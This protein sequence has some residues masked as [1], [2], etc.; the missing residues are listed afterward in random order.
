[1]LDELFSKYAPIIGAYLNSDGDDLCKPWL[2]VV[3]VIFE[4]NVDRELKLMSELAAAFNNASR[5]NY[6]RIAASSLDFHFI[7][8]EMTEEALI[9]AGFKKGVGYLLDEEGLRVSFNTA[10]RLVLSKGKPEVIESF[11]FIESVHQMFCRY[12]LA[13]MGRGRYKTHWT[14][15][16]R[17]DKFSK[18]MRPHETGISQTPG[19][20]GTGPTMNAQPMVFRIITGTR[21]SVV[22]LLQRV[23]KDTFSTERLVP[24]FESTIHSLDDEIDAV[25][26][27][28]TQTYA[29]PYREGQLNKPDGDGNEVTKLSKTKHS[30]KFLKNVILIDPSQDAYTREMLVQNIND[31]R[32]KLK[33]GQTTHTSDRLDSDNTTSIERFISSKGKFFDDRCLFKLSPRRDDVSV[34]EVNESMTFES[35]DSFGLN[36]RASIDSFSGSSRST[37]RESD[38]SIGTSSGGTGRRLRSVTCDSTLSSFSAVADDCADDN[39]SNEDNHV[40]DDIDEDVDEEADTPPAAPTKSTRVRTGSINLTNRAVRR[41]R[42]VS[43]NRPMAKGGQLDAIQAGD[44][45]VSEDS[46]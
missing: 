23:D 4:M 14:L 34:I 33:L 45:E 30:I 6:F 17:I 42:S 3:N 7:D 16:E 37:F 44:S 10:R 8:F 35:Y 13:M 26:Q 21:T 38:G 22:K 41:S 27:H 43:G 20:R 46:E 40:D 25:I 39:E 9:A 19:K 12:E 31:V 11:E 28:I 29:L 1:M 15:I 2:D 36:M 18:P 32:M 5:P 24:I